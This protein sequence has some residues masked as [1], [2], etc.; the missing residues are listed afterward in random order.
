MTF[1]GG[2]IQANTF[3]V[4]GAYEL[5]A[6]AGLGLGVGYDVV[7]D[8]D[9]DGELSN[10]DYID[11][12]DDEA[13]LYMVHDT[14][15]AGPLAVTE[16]SSYSVGTVFGIPSGYTNQDLYY[17]TNIGSMGQLP[18]I[19]ISH[20][21]GHNYQWYEAISATTWPPTATS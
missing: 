14:T 20:G 21:N 1:T 11:G 2:T 12:L 10:A 13:G 15:E 18:L 8:F 5:N 9:G 7:L 4:A 17:P 19:V 6:D 3:T 16:I